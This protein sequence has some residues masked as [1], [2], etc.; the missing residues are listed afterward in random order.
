MKRGQRVQITKAQAKAW[1][2]RW[3][4]VNEMDLAAAKRRTPAERYRGL[5]Q[6]MQFALSFPVTPERIQ[7][8]E[9]ARK[10]WLKLHEAYRARHASARAG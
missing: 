1:R 4:R 7:E 5:L 6:M 2:A 8:E 10:R 3:E 9:A